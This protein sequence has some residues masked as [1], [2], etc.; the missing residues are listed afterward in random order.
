MDGEIFEAML[1]LGKEMAE[2]RDG[3]EQDVGEQPN[4]TLARLIKVLMWWLLVTL[5]F[6]GRR[7]GMVDNGLG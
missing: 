1:E 4:Y 6:Y 2:G 7:N 5:Q 3:I